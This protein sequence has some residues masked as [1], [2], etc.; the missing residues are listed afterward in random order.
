[1]GVCGWE[2]ARA[3]GGGGG[4][5][6][7]GDRGGGGGGRWRWISGGLASCLATG[8]KHR[9]SECEVAK[10]PKVFATNLH[11]ALCWQ[12]STLSHLALHNRTQQFDTTARHKLPM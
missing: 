3:S 10:P 8:A 6:G 9:M 4:G 1:M 12:F 5:G 2:G 7:A 11:E